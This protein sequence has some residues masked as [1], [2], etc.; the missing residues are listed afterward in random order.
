MWASNRL[1]PH[2]NRIGTRHLYQCRAFVP[3]H[4][5]QSRA[6]VPG[7]PGIACTSNRCCLGRV[8]ARKPGSRD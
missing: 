3:V 2:S 8:V 1:V 4:L 6:F 7:V 5:Y